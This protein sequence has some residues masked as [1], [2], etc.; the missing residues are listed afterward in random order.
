M[1]IAAQAAALNAT[2][3]GALNM[4]QLRALSATDIAEL[5]ATQV[6]AF[7]A[8]QVGQLTT[9][10]FA[11]FDAT[12]VAA[13]STTQFRGVTAAQIRQAFVAANPG[14]PARAVKE[15]LAGPQGTLYGKNTIGGAIK[16]VT[17]PLTPDFGST[18]T[19]AVGNYSQLDVKS[20]LNLP[21]GTTLRQLFATPNDKPLETYQQ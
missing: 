17:K 21:L 8:T 6:E 15:V 20:S 11:A 12:Q 16:Y 3:L 9:T 4:S 1:A 2:Q 14:L 13:L 18:T 10:A 5:S 19:V 7:S